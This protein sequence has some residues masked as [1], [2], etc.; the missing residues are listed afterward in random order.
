M[1]RTFCKSERLCSQALI[2]DLFASGQK[3]MAFPYSIHYKLLP[4]GSL[5]MPAQ[6]LI[7]TSKRKFHHAVD[8]N[9]VKR[10]TRE[11]YR[12]R[13]DNLYSQLQEQGLSMT[14]S[15]NYIHTS[16]MDYAT[17]SHKFDKALR[18]LSTLIESSAD[19]RQDTPPASLSALT[20]Q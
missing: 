1:P 19:M 16:I 2:D 4:A 9:R 12:L 7:T 5:P 3:L 6:V 11:C 15:F 18:Q 13:K 10:L 17:L 14:I 20:T 8:R